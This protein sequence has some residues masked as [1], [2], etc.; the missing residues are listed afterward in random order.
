MDTITPAINDKFNADTGELNTEFILETMHEQRIETIFDEFHT[1]MDG[2]S[3]DA[4][5]SDQWA[6]GLKVHALG[7]RLRV[8]DTLLRQY[9]DA[10]IKG[11]NQIT[12]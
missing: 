10:L 12:V 3:E 7:K 6:R 8:F 11:E 1:L 9:A 5:P 4:S 2:D